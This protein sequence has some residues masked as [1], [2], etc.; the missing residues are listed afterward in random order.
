MLINLKLYA[1]CAAVII[2]LVSCSYMYLS[3][4]IEKAVNEKYTAEVEKLKNEQ[5]QNLQ[6]LQHEQNVIVTGYIDDIERLKA[7]HEADLKELENAKFKDTVTIEPVTTADCGMHK[8]DNGKAAVPTAGN[9]PDLICY[10]RTEL[11]R[12]IERSL[13]ITKECDSLSV[14]YKALLEVCTQNEQK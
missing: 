6:Q 9:K 5:L 10:T 1:I 4:R 13:D 2:A 11:Q 8:D 7:Q 14:R 3:Y 12:K